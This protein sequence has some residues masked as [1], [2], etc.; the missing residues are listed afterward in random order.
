MG[1]TPFKSNG[2]VPIVQCSFSRASQH[3]LSY[4]MIEGLAED[5]TDYWTDVHVPIL[6][7]P[8]LFDFARE[9]LMR[10]HPVILRNTSV[11][12]WPALYAWN[13]EYLSEKL[14]ETEISVSLTPDGCADSV[15]SLRIAGKVEERFVYPAEIKITMQHF[16]TTLGYPSSS[17]V[18]YLSQQNDNLR[19]EC[20]VLL[21][22]IDK[23]SPLDDLFNAPNGPEAVNLWIGDERSVSSLHK[24]H[25]ENMYIVISGAKTFTL[26][27]PTDIAFLPIN[28]YPTARYQANPNP[29]YTKHS[30]QDEYILEL[31]TCNC[32]SEQIEWIP[33][34]P[35]KRVSAVQRHPWFRYTRPLHCTVYPG[36]MLY[37][38]AMWYHRV[39]Q[40]CKTV[41]VNYW[42]DMRFDFR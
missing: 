35:N 2:P 25:F 18:P 3:S 28:T 9:G 8:T 5:T 12:E 13:D 6:D 40:E 15:Q 23:R 10:Y 22:D 16:L 1:L 11:I 37:I 17:Y 41:A 14:A 42:Y 32:P 31:T 38:P 27:P 4:D 34:D 33:I 39:S 30:I 20:N 29:N 7:Y 26:L 19:T 36:E 21:D 24:D